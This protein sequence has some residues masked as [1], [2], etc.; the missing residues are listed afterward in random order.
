MSR[1]RKRFEKIMNNPKD[2][3]WDLFVT[4]IEHYGITVDNP[5]G[6]SHFI[7]YSDDDDEMIPVP[8]H[9][10]RIKTVYAKKIIALIEKLNS[11]EE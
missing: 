8:V 5:S 9:N 6:G 1:I 10:N 2:V 11:E 7:V 4:V 3:K